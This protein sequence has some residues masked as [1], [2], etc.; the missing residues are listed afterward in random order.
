MSIFKPCDIRGIYGRDLTD[1]DAYLLGR[2]SGGMGPGTALVAGDVR[3]STPAL[4]TALRQGLVDAGCRVTD[5]GIMTTPAFY[6]AVRQTNS[7][8][9]VMVTASHNP[10]EYNG[11]KL[12]IDQ[13]P[14]DQNQLAYLENK[15]KTKDFVAGR[16][17][18]LEDPSWLER[19][20]DFMINHFHPGEVHVVLDCGNG[21]CC[22]AAPRI[23]RCLGYRVTELFSTPDGRFPNR[24]P[25]PAI[26]ENLAA[27]RESVVASKA[28]LGIAYD[29]DG[30]RV[31][32]VTEKG[33]T[34]ANDRL[35]ALFSRYLIN[36]DVV[37][38]DSKCSLVVAEEVTR[39]GGTPVMARSGHAFVGTKFLK[40]N[41]LLAGELSG[42][43][44]WRDL[45]FDDGIFSSLVLAQLLQDSRT[46]LSRLDEAIPHYL[47]TPDIRLNY[48]GN[49]E[50]LVAAIAQ[51]L[52]A[53]PLSHIDGIRVQPEDCWGLI[54]PSI[55]EP[56]V[57]MRFEGKTSER[58]SYIINLVLA[59]LPDELR[60]AALDRLND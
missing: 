45:G 28:A 36:R 7:F 34:I 9:G 46:S 15:I 44:F 47:I 53:Y 23:F 35:L 2:A 10:P 60:T 41:A 13:R 57:T 29:G 58:L 33:L 59:V 42:H 40:R 52:A 25:N 31:A 27:V 19:Y 21:S 24:S 37:V 12:R 26:P 48:T 49:P 17:S 11:F 5:A 6:F 43:F 18:Y 1:Q 50:N 22:L 55:T 32:F 8:V 51:K 39:L 38:Y 16:G 20:C 4:K 54:R 3:L 14:A 30:D 56:L